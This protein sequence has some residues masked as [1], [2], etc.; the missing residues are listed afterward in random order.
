MWK[1]SH[2]LP[3]AFYPIQSFCRCVE[4]HFSLSLLLMPIFVIVAIRSFGE[5]KILCKSGSGLLK[6]RL[7][8]LHLHVQILSVLCE[9]K[10]RACRIERE[11][12]ERERESDCALLR[13]RSWWVWKLSLRSLC[14][15]SSEWEKCLL[16]AIAA[17]D[18]VAVI[19]TFFSW[20][21]ECVCSTFRSLFL[22]VV[23]FGAWL[24]IAI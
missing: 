4:L 5:N 3:V 10:H 9:Y 23:L 11:R 8:L 19:H 6:Y 12:S 24:F 14:N 21:N 22:M 20:T 7:S 18:F 2:L 1:F 13:A 15:D 17:A 16:I